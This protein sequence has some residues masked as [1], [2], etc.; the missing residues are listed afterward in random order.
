MNDPTQANR[1]ERKRL[2]QLDHLAD[3]AWALFEAQG[4]EAVTME[5]VAAAADVAKGTLYKH[6]PAKEALLRHRFH[7]EL[8]A[9]WPA[10]RDELAALAPGRARLARFLAMQARW[11]EQQRSYLLP[12]VRY[13]LSSA[14]R[15][16]ARSERSGMDRIFAGLIAEG[17]AAGEFRSDVSAALLATHLQFAHLATVLRWLSEDGL[18]LADEMAQ[19]L[20]LVCNGIGARP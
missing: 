13:R 9:V 8:G 7:R 1:R 3:T 15:F 5:A 6:F 14:E 2:Q 18:S 16:D 17:Q 12:Y 20:D 19:M 11:C 4:F 10:L